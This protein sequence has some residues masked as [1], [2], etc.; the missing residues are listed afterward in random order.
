M[1]SVTLNKPLSSMI[2]LQM[3]PSTPDQNLGQKENKSDVLFSS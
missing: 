3:I 2:D 1:E